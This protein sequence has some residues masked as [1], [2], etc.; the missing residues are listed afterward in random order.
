MKRIVCLCVILLC[1]VSF[2]FA[3]GG[4]GRTT[5]KKPVVKKIDPQIAEA[6][7]A[8]TPFYEKFLEVV[9][10]REREGLKKLLSV[11]FNDINWDASE[12]DFNVYYWEVFERMKKVS[13]LLRKG[14]L[15]SGVGAINTTSSRIVSDK[16]YDGK[17]K[18]ACQDSKNDNDNCGWKIAIFEYRNGK[19]LLAAFTFCECE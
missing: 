3:Q 9:K 15:I 2:A 12:E 13:R 11:D 16:W 8:W 5:K 4:R 10:N 1:S 7:K 14:E 19:W 6:E 17:D 18:S